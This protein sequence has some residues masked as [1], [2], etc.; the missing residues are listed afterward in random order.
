MQKQKKSKG[1][2][3]VASQYDTLKKKKAFLTET[4]PNICFI[5]THFGPSRIIHIILKLP[6]T[7]WINDKCQ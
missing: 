7:I 2:D 4:K 3:I 6:A 1:I 5:H